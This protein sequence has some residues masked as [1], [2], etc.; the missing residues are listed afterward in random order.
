[1]G[2]KSIKPTLIE[3]VER[4]NVSRVLYQ[5]IQL[6][7]AG[8]RWNKMQTNIMVQL[9]DLMQERIKAAAR[10]KAKS[11]A[12]E[13]KWPSIFTTAEMSATER[14]PVFTIPFSDL[15]VSSKHYPFVAEVAMK[16][17]N[18]HVYL[19]EGDEVSGINLFERITVPVTATGRKKGIIS[20]VP[21]ASAMEKVFTLDKGYSKAIKDA[22]IA[23][24]HHADRIYMNLMQHKANGVWH[25][26]YKY[27]RWLLKLDYVQKYEDFLSEQKDSKRPKRHE[28]I[29]KGQVRV[30][31]YSRFRDFNDNVLKKT[32]DAINSLA[33]QDMLDISIKSIE[34]KDNVS[35]EE[36]PFISFHIAKTELGR[37]MDE[38][39]KGN[40]EEYELRSVMRKDLGIT[41]AQ[42]AY[43]LQDVDHKHYSKI[44]DEVAK[45][46]TNVVA[47]SPKNKVAY[48]YSC[49]CNFIDTIRKGIE[50]VD[51]VEVKIPQKPTVKTPEPPAQPKSEDP[52]LIPGEGSDKW[53]ALLADY[54]GP[55]ADL[56]QEAKFVGMEDGLFSIWYSDYLKS[57]EATDILTAD[58]KLVALLRKYSDVPPIGPKIRITYPK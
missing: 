33:S 4:Y 36:N 15:G 20:F 35:D 49:L 22:I 43:C 19:H 12:E 57:R 42:A 34:I 46:K 29:D 44:Y 17:L 8:T 45:I 55:N 41:V 52:R 24:P 32:Q 11:I 9:L 40:K 58:E 38:S 3:G 14:R 26:N 25:T 56:L 37:L 21:T 18:S 28:I 48:A 2:R 5:P 54:D 30:S 47:N 27:L 39:S 6:V 23:L 50:D 10:E 51:S 13:A 1:M 31:E 16:L 53:A 7:S